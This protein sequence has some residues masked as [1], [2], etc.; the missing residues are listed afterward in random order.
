MVFNDL[1]P[2]TTSFVG[3]DADLDAVR[4]L[5][6]DVRL[7]SITGPG[8]MGKTRL[9]RRIAVA[10]EPGYDEVC[11]VELAGLRHAAEVP[12]ALASALGLHIGAD[13]SALDR[14]V[15]QL[16][17][18]A[19]LLVLD[20]GEHLSAA[21]A[22][23]AVEL[24][25]RCPRVHL[26]VTSR[27]SLRV[28]GEQVYRIPPL[29]VPGP[30]IADPAR[31][32]DCPAVM[33]LADRARAVRADFRVTDDNAADV[34]R[35]CRLL[36][37]VPLAIELAAA[38]LRSLSARQILDRWSG[39][40]AL[41]GAWS[42]G[43]PDRQ[44][45]V[46]ATVEWSYRLCTADERAVWTRLSIFR[47]WF[48]LEAAEYLCAGADVATP[49]HEVVDSLVDTCVLERRG[50]DVAHFRL[51]R[52]MR[53]LGREHLR[54]A[55]LEE[56]L[57]RR[58]RDWFRELV[59]LADR[60]FL[61]HRQHELVT[62][63]RTAQ[64][65]LRRALEWSVDTPGE[66]DAAV[67]MVACVDE[68]WTMTGANREV[69]TWLHRALAAAPDSPYAS[70]G[71]VVAALHSLAISDRAAAERDLELAAAAADPGDPVAAARITAVHALA[72]K[73]DL[74]NLRAAELAERAVT[75]LRAHGHEREALG[76]WNIAV[77]ATAADD[78]DGR[79]AELRVA[80]ARCAERGD[81]HYSCVLR[82]SISLIEVMRGNPDAAADAAVAALRHSHWWES[83]YGDAYHI[84]SLA[85]VAAAR[86]RHHR[87]ATLFGIAAAA[88]DKLG[89]HAAVVLVRPHTRYRTAT[90]DALGAPAF[91]RA[92]RAGYTMPLSEAIEFAL[93]EAEPPEP[94]PLTPRE[95]E[96]AAL[97]AAGLTNR[98]IAAELVIATRTADTHLR[99]ILAKL[100]IANRTRLATWMLA[101][102]PD[103]ASGEANT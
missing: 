102:T 26:L 68:F 12:A 69:R 74:D 81:F 61:G 63:L 36:D 9:A 96:V 54:A 89:A 70:R 1:D 71:R 72:A 13:D 83:R 100:G 80:V 39:W 8:G 22:E 5:V 19:V 95:L 91:A 32:R 47:D 11:F 49:M 23:V 84:E 45:T 48:E 40:L 24:L 38:Q 18:R 35:L 77:L 31:L 85:W 3:R 37:G 14:V 79:L 73:V 92:H 86:E 101:R 56:Q 52:S 98:E 6:D 46:R 62:R 41:P 90:E 99:N 30:D 59:L 21:V 10:L 97:V 64:P 76:A 2:V 20:N 4:R 27:G 78:P 67:Q 88:W 16:A 51:P 33:L 87:A 29:T 82:F 57:T 34:A 15:G 55:G 43:V 93:A 42:H 75:V 65:D 28:P 25:A 7:V 17:P 66:A 60:E 44:R 103:R 50:E 94:V 53:E 58:H